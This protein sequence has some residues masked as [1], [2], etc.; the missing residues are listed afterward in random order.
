MIA[1]SK[2]S[3]D[4]AFDHFERFPSLKALLHLC[5]QPGRPSPSFPCMYVGSAITLLQS[6]EPKKTAITYLDIF[7]GTR[8]QQESNN[9]SLTTDAARRGRL[10]FLS[11]HCLHFSERPLDFLND[12]NRAAKQTS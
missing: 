10:S 7:V 8:S 2:C 5:T 9:Y 6:K 1:C 4:D 11:E 12:K 3:I